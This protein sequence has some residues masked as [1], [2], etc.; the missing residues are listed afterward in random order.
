MKHNANLLPHHHPAAPGVVNMVLKCYLC[1]T[2]VQTIQ[3]FFRIIP[4]LIPSAVRPNG[5]SLCTWV[6]WLISPSN[7]KTV[8]TSSVTRNLVIYKDGVR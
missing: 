6:Q 5:V 1:V 4:G 7:G 2:W 3:S 8:N